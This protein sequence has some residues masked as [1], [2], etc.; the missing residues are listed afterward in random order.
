MI[1]TNSTICCFKRSKSSPHTSTKIPE[2]KLSIFAITLATLTFA[3]LLTTSLSCLTTNLSKSTAP[4]PIFEIN[5][6]L[7]F[8]GSPDQTLSIGV[9]AGFLTR[10]FAVS[11]HLRIPDQMLGN[12]GDALA[13]I[14]EDGSAQGVLSLLNSSAACTSMSNTR[15]LLFGLN[16]GAEET[17]EDM[18]RP[19]NAILVF[20]LAV[21]N[22]D[23]YAG[24]FEAG[25]E[26]KGRVHR[27]LGNGM[28]E[29]C[30]APWK[31][32]AITSL[33]VH[34]G[35]LYAASSRYH[36]DDPRLSNSS[37]QAD[38][39]ELFRYEG[40]QAWSYCGK[41]GPAEF[42]YGMVSA[43]EDLLITLMDSPR[44]LDSVEYGLYSYHPDGSISFLGNPGGRV[45]AISAAHGKAYL[46]GYDGT[47]MGGL[48]TFSKGEGWRNVGSPPNVSQSYSM[49]TYHGRLHIG[50][51]PE[52]TVYGL[53]DAT[54]RFVSLGRLGQENEVMGMMV[55]NGA[56]YAGTLPSAHVFRFLPGQ[57]IW[58][59]VGTL[60]F[61]T[62]G[63]RRAWGMAIYRG[64]LICST[65]PTG[66]VLGMELGQV[67]TYDRSLDAQW[68]HLIVQRRN[69]QLELFM[70]GNLISRRSIPPEPLPSLK[71]RLTLSL[72]AGPQGPFTGSIRK[73]GIYDCALHPQ[74]R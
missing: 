30:G 18:G 11:M 73:F 66:R 57:G 51:W 2:Y 16:S 41:I 10:E 48:F 38:G 43:G 71:R 26:E 6:E 29:D 40:G 31:A 47:P 25:E 22:G 9:D 7:T 64:K 52:G 65:L 67:L 3:C 49:V 45:A 74:F 68:H 46:T 44:R 12:L 61:A 33:A 59:Q 70:D 58:K 37:N 69:D 63:R 53:D 54:S 14:D 23:L 42:V 5:E 27:Y 62:V 39:G 1:H 50:T 19:A 4:R 56:L 55:Y 24:S 21:F 8:S 35:H 13:F 15:N 20:A 60:D 28:W 17:W 34:N 32:N 36:E 72:G